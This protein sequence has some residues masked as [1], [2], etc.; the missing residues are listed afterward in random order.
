M[1]QT[2][3]GLFV[4][5]YFVLL[6]A[7]AMIGG[8]VFRN[9]MSP[10]AWTQFSVDAERHGAGDALLGVLLYLAFY[11]MGFVI[12]WSVLSFATWSRYVN[13]RREIAGINLGAVRARVRLTSLGCLIA[14]VVLLDSETA[15]LRSLPTALWNGW[16]LI[17]STAASGYLVLEGILGL[18]SEELKTW[19]RVR[20]SDAIACR[21]PKCGNEWSFSADR[22]R[23]HNI[24]FES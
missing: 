3:A 21:C 17:L 22:L 11:S 10:W 9:E 23:T 1:R 18:W 14:F 24:I 8:S 5:G 4:A 7:A 6:L 15:F 12:P 16:F 2:K 19:V 20:P 13:Q